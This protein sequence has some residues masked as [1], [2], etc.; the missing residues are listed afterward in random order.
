MSVWRA[1]SALSTAGNRLPTEDVLRQS[2]WLQ[3]VGSF[4]APPSR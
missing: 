3:P 4:P 1:G 2:S